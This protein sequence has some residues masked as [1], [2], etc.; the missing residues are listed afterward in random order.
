MIQAFLVRILL[1]PLALLYGLAMSVRNAIYG[2]GLLRHT[3]FNIPVIGLGNLSIGGAGKTPHVEYLVRLLSPYIQLATMSRGYKRETNGFRLATSKDTALSIGDEPM[4]YFLKYPGLAVSVSESRSIGIPQ[5]LSDRPDIQCILLDDAFQHLSV[6]PGLSILLTE[7]S[8]PYYSDFLLPAGRL[9]EWPSGADRA[10]VVIVSKCPHELPETER[11][12]IEQRLDLRPEQKIFY[13][14]YHYLDP[15]LLGTGKRFTLKP[16]QSAL[17]LSSIANV[18]YITAY[19][20]DQLSELRTL[21]F[22]DHHY[23]TERE[24]NVVKQSFEAIPGQNKL[25]IT[26]EKD[27]TR[28]LL[29]SEFIQTMGDH[30]SVLPVEV[31]FHFGAGKEFDQMVKTFLLNFKV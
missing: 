21:S 19:L 2:L 25:I 22:E 1:M 30:L 29:H 9:R 18:D 17:L 20:K 4:M 8:H 6:K 31:R 15:Y 11:Q 28:L 5:L 16:T 3:Q 26:T 10:D 23:Y 7:Y 24:L 14:Y 12:I 13:T 27:A